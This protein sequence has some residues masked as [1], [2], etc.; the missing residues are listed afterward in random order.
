MKKK[1]VLTEGKKKGGMSPACTGE[2]MPNR[3]TG[4][5]PSQHPTITEG[6]K[7][8]GMSTVSTHESTTKR[9]TSPPPKRKASVGVIHDHMETITGQRILT[10]FD[11]GIVM[12][13]DEICYIIKDSG[14]L[15]SS[16]VSGYT[17]AADKNIKESVFAFETVPNILKIPFPVQTWYF[18]KVE[19]L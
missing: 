4:P 3:P 17:H 18:N 1:T 11:D 19:N 16:D 7:K 5:P 13:F 8:E 12:F 6:K 15:Y 14:T 10:G 2:V 9:P